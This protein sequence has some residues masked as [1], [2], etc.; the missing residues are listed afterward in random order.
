MPFVDLLAIG[1]LDGLHGRGDFAPVLA[2]IIQA[3]T[4]AGDIVGEPL[5]K[6]VRIIEAGAEAPVAAVMA[7]GEDLHIEPH[8]RSYAEESSLTSVIWNSVFTPL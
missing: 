1:R 2:H 3:L 4:E 5:A 6:P 8:P 7:V